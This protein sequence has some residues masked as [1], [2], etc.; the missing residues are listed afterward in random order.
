MLANRKT[1]GYT[2]G[3]ILINGGPRDQFF[4]RFSAYVEQQDIL[5]PL[6][7]VYESVLFS[8]QVRLPREISKADIDVR[9][10]DTLKIL[11]LEGIQ[12]LFCGGL[13][14]EQ[15]KR[16][17][18]AVELVADPELLFLDGMHN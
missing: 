15:K 1:G 17:T 3:K 7:T 18:I 6:A 8:A 2:E 9:I 13:S 12:N 14:L 11:D 5:M 10:R 4:S 16:V